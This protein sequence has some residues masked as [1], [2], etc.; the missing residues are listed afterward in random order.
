MRA[1]GAYGRP[2]SLSEGEAEEEAG[3]D[4]S[5]TNDE[6]GGGYESLTEEQFFEEWWERNSLTLQFENL[7]LN[8]HLIY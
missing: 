6:E 7:V 8:E 3:S 2:S 1:K 5:L 4:D